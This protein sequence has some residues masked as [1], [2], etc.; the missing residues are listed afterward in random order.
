MAKSK[1]VVQVSITSDEPMKKKDI[2]A[3]VEGALAPALDGKKV[4]VRS[5]D[6]D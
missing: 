1:Y 3:A 2:K 5:V 6:E 4:R